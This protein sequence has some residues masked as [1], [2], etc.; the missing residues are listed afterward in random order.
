MASD[1]EPTLS[2]HDD[3]PFEMAFETVQFAYVLQIKPPPNR[4]G[5]AKATGSGM[6]LLSYSLGCD[7][8]WDLVINIYHLWQRNNLP[9]DAFA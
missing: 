3:R 9:S 4:V 5:L 8:A 6:L 1:A 7:H 2:Q